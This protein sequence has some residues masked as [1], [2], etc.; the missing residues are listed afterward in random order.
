[1]SGLE[2]AVEELGTICAQLRQRLA[3]AET[4]RDVARQQRDS[5]TEERVALL[6]EIEDFRRERNSAEEQVDKLRQERDAAFARGCAL[7]KEKLAEVR[8]EAREQLAEA[9]ASFSAADERELEARRALDKWVLADYVARGI[10]IDTEGKLST[11]G[12]IPT[13]RIAVDPANVGAAYIELAKKLNLLKPA[14]TVTA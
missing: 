3:S 12:S 5:A 7:Y 2:S 8:A 14:A 1:M 4:D 9:Y 13:R 6:K 11:F 10:S